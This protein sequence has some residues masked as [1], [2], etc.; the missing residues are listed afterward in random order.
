MVA[1]MAARDKTRAKARGGLNFPTPTARN[2]AAKPFVDTLTTT[3]SD[4]QVM[5]AFCE[6]DGRS[7]EV[8]FERYASPLRAL[9]IK[10]SRNESLAADI[11]Q[12][13]FVSVVR[14]RG[15]FIEG[16]RFKPWLYTIAL[17]ALRNKKRQLWREVASADEEVS[18]E[19][20]QRD[21]GLEE[22]LK[23][24]LAQLSDEQREAV[25]LHQVEGFSFKE[26]AEMLV[27]TESAV[28]VRAHRGY[29]RLRQILGE[30]WRHYE[31]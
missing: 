31:S 19:L 21:P 29:E 20:L 8:L 1:F 9:L 22:A 23:N 16:Y 13:T 17:N 2:V 7:L 10:L 30:T 18:V 3:L 4:E 27:Q 11:V 6:G 28:K 12:D 24:A 5:K 14:G 26:I 15:R 25:V